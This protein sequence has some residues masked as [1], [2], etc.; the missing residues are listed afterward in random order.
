MQRIHEQGNI[1]VCQQTN[2]LIPKLSVWEHLKLVC[3]I[4]G[5]QANKVEDEI[6]DAMQKMMISLYFDQRAEELTPM[7]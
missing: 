3:D 2:C 1:G 5:I 7:L 4:K 6:E